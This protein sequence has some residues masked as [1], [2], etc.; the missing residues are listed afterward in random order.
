[1]MEFLQYL[2]P[3]QLLQLNPLQ[4]FLVLVLYPVVFGLVGIVTWTLY[5]AIMRL[6]QVKKAGQ[7]PA[8]ALPF[9]Y[10]V[11]GVGYFLDFLFNLVA[12]VLFLEFP[13]EWIF[14]PRVIRHKDSPTWRGRLARWFC[15]TLLD[16]FDP[17][18]C[19]CRD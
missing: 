16:P 4:I 10:V 13:R 17:T 5:L 6:S 9:A 14:S 19:H 18:G 11:L 8:A 3:A 7:L 1:M 2:N 15:T 12:S